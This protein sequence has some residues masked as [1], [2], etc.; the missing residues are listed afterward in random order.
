MAAGRT[1]YA[2]EP[3]VLRER[4]AEAIAEEFITH[5]DFA[6]ARAECAILAEVAL[7]DGLDE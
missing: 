7:A 3:E 6:A 4:D 2:I 5:P 1:S